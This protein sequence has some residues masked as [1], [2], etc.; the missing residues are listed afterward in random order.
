MDAPNP[1]RELETALRARGYRVTTPRR[2]VWHVLHEA[3]GHLTVDEILGQAAARGEEIDQASV[4]RALGLFAE[5]GLARV[6]RLGERDAGRWEL[7]H[8]DE[9]F[10]LVCESCGAVD[11][12][13]GTLVAR[14]REHLEDEHGFSVS[15]VELV[16]T[17]RC[18][19]CRAS[20]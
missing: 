2:I 5:L 15:G 4:Y 17:G 11:H 16:V 20:A 9:H 6:N 18:R 14:V 7:A 12:H 10:H 1:S 13:A 3:S 8:P 19:R